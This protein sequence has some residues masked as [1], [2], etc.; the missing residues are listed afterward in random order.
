MS[1]IT[2]GFYEELFGHPEPTGCQVDK[3][4][5][6]EGPD[7]LLTK[8]G[9]KL[10]CGPQNLV[11]IAPLYTQITPRITITPIYGDIRTILPTL[12]NGSVV[13]CA[14]NFNGLE[15]THPNQTDHMISEYPNDHTQGPTVQLACLP[16]LVW[17]WNNV[18]RVNLLENLPL[19]MTAGGWATMKP[20]TPMIDYDS[21]EEYTKYRA[22]TA[23]S[24]VMGA[25]G[26]IVNLLIAAALDMSPAFNRAAAGA[27]NILKSWM[28]YFLRAAYIATL[29]SAAINK[30]KEIILTPI[31][32]GVFNNPFEEVIYALAW[33]LTHFNIPGRLHK[34]VSI[35]MNLYA[36]RENAGAYLNALNM[37]L[38]GD[39]TIHSLKNVLQI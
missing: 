31:G 2:L 32:S 25:P 26:T 16:Q 19:D 5:K 33:A 12:L 7:L 24:S 38:A 17:R 27:K 15:F 14:S 37:F 35:R 11:S 21:P 10:V 23:R 20:N 39:I 3:E 29:E 28:R 13:M 30:S 1:K 22:I 4:L 18:G 8:T 36:P 34:D 6:Y 9:E